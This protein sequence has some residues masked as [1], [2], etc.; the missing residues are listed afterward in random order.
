M[1]E[2]DIN[3]KRFSKAELLEALESLFLGHYTSAV[4][5]ALEP[6]VKNEIVLNYLAIKKII[7]Q[8]EAS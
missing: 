8:S 7:K 2:E 1:R 4:N 5:E 6:D 3:I